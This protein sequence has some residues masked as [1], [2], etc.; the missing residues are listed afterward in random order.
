MIFWGGTIPVFKIFRTFR[1]NLSGSDCVY[2]SDSVSQ[3]FNMACDY[4][5]VHEAQNYAHRNFVRR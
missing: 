4:T 3:V 2:I 5:G 1:F